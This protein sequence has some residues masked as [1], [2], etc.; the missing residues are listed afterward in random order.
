MRHDSIARALRRFGIPSE[1]AHAILDTYKST[2]TRI[3][4]SNES[5]RPIEILNG[6]KQGDP[7]SPLL[8]NMVMDELI[9]EVNSLNIGIEVG[10]AK[11]SILAFADDLVLLTQN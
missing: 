3:F 1:V 4:T 6:V 7:L 8:F 11:V 9:T 10:D 5:T 2:S